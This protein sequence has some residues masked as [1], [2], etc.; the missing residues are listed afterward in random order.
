MVSSKLSLDK[1]ICFTVDNNNITDPTDIANA[2][3]NHFCDSIR[4]IGQTF[5]NLTDP[6]CAHNNLLI[7]AIDTFHFKEVCEYTVYK[8]LHYVKK[9]Q[10]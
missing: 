10:W 7:D 6:V 4:V 8:A 2:F 5:S 1:P 9:T 3:A